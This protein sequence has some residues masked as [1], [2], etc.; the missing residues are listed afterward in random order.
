MFAPGGRRSR[1]R[2]PRGARRRRR[3]ARARHRHRPDRAAARAARRSRAR[4]RP[5]DGD[6]R[7]AAREAGRR[8]DRRRRSATSRRPRV[9]GTFTLA[10]L[11]FNTI[12]NL[13]TQDA[14]VA[15]FRNVAAHLEPG[16]CFVIEVGVPDLQRLPPGET[17]PAVPRQ[18]RRG[19][20]STSTTSRAQGLISH[21]YRRSRAA[22]L[23][24]RLDAVPLRVAGG[25]RPDG[26]ARRA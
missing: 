17:L 5:V 2:L 19:S 4:H 14:Q 12:M 23:E 11:V 9:D 8:G 18:R 6:G 22:R 24:A 1:R 10:Y 7:A 20:A 3:R 15:C 16:G 26:A 13:T 21:H 25:A